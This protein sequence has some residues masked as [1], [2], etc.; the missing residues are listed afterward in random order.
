MRTLLS[1]SLA[2]LLALSATT[3]H[4]APILDFGMIAL[5]QGSLSWAGGSNPLIG[6]NITIDNLI[7]SET[8]VDNGVQRAC[9]NCSLSFSTGNYL[10]ASSNTWNYAGGGLLTINGQVDL[11]GDLL[12][13]A[14]YGTL[15][16]ASFDSSS[17]FN[18][19]FGTFKLQILGAAFDGT[20]DAALASHY[21][22]QTDVVGGIN[23][24]F[25]ANAN[26]G[27]AFTSNALYSG[28]IMLELTTV[29]IPPSAWLF[30]A[31]MIGLVAVGRRRQALV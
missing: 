13:D 25:S 24:S 15:L 30:G 26:P 5:T 23:L 8:A 10:G 20:L 3:A 19:G 1:A 27:Q 12:P 21:L 9:L 28:D 4:A 31:G 11:D 16:T 17:V 18:V 22:A 29:P 14:P 6:T 2:S 7:A